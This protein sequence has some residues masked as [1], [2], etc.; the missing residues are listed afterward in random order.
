MGM[1]AC[2]LGGGHSLEALA[3]GV[4]GRGQDALGG[5]PGG[6]TPLG[7]AWDLLLLNDAR[8]LA[9]TLYHTQL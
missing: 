6:H 4:T 3:V 5:T 2:L 1:S 8:L 9:L 7:G